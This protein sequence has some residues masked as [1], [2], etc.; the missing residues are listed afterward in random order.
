L[1]IVTGE[2][3]IVPAARFELVTAM[4]AEKPPRTDIKLTAFPAESSCAETTV[5]IVF[6]DAVD[7][8]KLDTPKPPGPAMRKPEGDS[9][10]VPVV[11]PKP[12]PAVAVYGT[13]PVLP[14]ACR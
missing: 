7:V 3:V 13:F 9:V 14:R 4:F 1:P 11:L 12:D 5:R 2:V 10:T 6:P 8:E